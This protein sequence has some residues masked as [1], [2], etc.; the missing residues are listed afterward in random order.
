MIL[1]AI[2]KDLPIVKI[3]KNQNLIWPLLCFVRDDV[4]ESVCRPTVHWGIG[5][6]TE[7]V[8]KL[9]DAEVVI[10]GFVFFVDF[11]VFSVVII[12]VVD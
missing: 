8:G 3:R 4:A 5:F 7:V 2:Q 10:E 6:H 11:A 9:E 12:G 1:H